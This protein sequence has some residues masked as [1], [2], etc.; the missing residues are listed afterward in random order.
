MRLF[1]L[2]VISTICL[3]LFTSCNKLGDSTP[4]LVGEWSGPRGEKL[5]FDQYGRVSVFDHSGKLASTSGYQYIAGDGT[6]RM[7]VPD[8]TLVGK[9]VGKRRLQVTGL[10]GRRRLFALKE[11]DRGQPGT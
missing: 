9:I 5:F 10:D 4:S 7:P 8:G 11:P 6:V 2:A 3:S 1:A